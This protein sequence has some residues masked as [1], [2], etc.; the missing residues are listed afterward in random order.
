MLVPVRHRPL[1]RQGDRGRIECLN[2]LAHGR[3]AR[4]WQF[5]R[6]RVGDGETMQRGKTWARRRDS[7]DAWT[8]EDARDATYGRTSHSR[9]VTLRASSG[10]G[11]RASRGRSSVVAPGPQTHPSGSIV[12]RGEGDQDQEGADHGAFEVMGWD[13]AGDLPTDEH[14][15]KRGDSD[16][17]DQGPVDGALAEVAEGADG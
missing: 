5:T 3:V 13:G 11:S 6:L 7:S 14:P 16:D 2:D 10:G 9:C 17:G 12:Q 15:A 8:G 4:R 1:K